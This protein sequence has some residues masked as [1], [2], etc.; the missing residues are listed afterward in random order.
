MYYPMTKRSRV[1][2]MYSYNY[3]YMRQKMCSKGKLSSICKGSNL[4]IIQ[5]L[6]GPAE[7]LRA[8]AMATMVAKEYLS[9]KSLKE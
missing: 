9:Q 7:G 6:R 4:N 5:Y 1:K 2:P 8:V 3:T